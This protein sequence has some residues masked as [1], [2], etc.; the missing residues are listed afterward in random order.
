M[1]NTVRLEAKPRV[2]ITVGL[3]Y[4]SQIKTNALSKGAIYVHKRPQNEA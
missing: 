3:G 2:L 4:S 1:M